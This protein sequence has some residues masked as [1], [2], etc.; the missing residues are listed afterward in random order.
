[1][2]ESTGKSRGSTF[3]VGAVGAAVAAFAAVFAVDGVREDLCGWVVPL[4]ERNVIGCGEQF[5]PISPREAEE[6]LALYYGRAGGAQPEAAWEMQTADARSMTNRDDFNSLWEGVYWA[7]IVGPLEASDTSFNAFSVG[8][9]YYHEDG[10]VV[11]RREESVLTTEEGDIFLDRKD[12]HAWREDSREVAYPR[13]KVISSVNTYQMARSD[14]QPAMF[15]H[16]MNVGGH[17]LGLCLLEEGSE[18][19]AWIRTPQGWIS[20]DSVD[21]SAAK[22]DAMV[23][24]DERYST[25]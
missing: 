22:L 14:A 21:V 9:R 24:C 25:F 17:L 20:Y 23:R 12:Q 13:V 15:A 7:E 18:D 19:V 2:G 11:V 1:M 16:E 6:F 10:S 4:L 8:V 3:V 5:E